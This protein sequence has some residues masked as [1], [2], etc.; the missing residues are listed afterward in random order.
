M[1]TMIELSGV[2]LRIEAHTIL[3]DLSFSVSKGESVAL[4]GPN[5]SGKTSVLRCLLGLAPFSGRAAIGGHDVSARPLEARTLTAYLPQ[6]AAFGDSTP[7][8]A[9]T[10]VARLRR[11]DT[12]RIPQVLERVG[13]WSHAKQ[14]ARTFSGGMQQRLS[15]AVALLSDAP[16]LLMDEPTASLDR[17]GQRTFFDIVDA[18]RREGRTLLLSSHRPEEVQRLT[19]RVLQLEAGRLAAPEPAS[20]A[21]F[22]HT[23]EGIAASSVA[24]DPPVPVRRDD[25]PTEPARLESLRVSNALAPVVSLRTKGVRR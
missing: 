19:D 4:T 11:L 7:L 10:F 1:N 2:S 8:E 5:G 24:G 13:L 20:S 9:L 15:L 6:R 21:K 3:D 12:D 16:V 17:D 25:C 18:L 22:L 23:V 14:R